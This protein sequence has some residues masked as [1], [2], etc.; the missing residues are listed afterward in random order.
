M[1]VV[2]E[3]DSYGL[4]D[5]LQIAAGFGMQRFGYVVTP[6]VDHFVRLHEDAGL[7]EAYAEADYVLLDS[8][9][10]AKLLELS[11]GMKVSVT[12]GSDLTAALFGS[13]IAPRDRIVVIGGSAQLAQGLARRHGLLEL[14]HHAPP[15][16]FLDDPAALEACLEFIEGHSPFRFCFL[17][18][19]S[20][21]QEI[22]ARTLRLRG[23][24]RG[25]ALCI[26]AAL[27]FL[28][29]ERERA[30]LWMQRSSLEWLHRL[31]QDPARLAHRYLVRGPRVFGLLRSTRISVR[32]A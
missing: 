28:G 18:V 27:E 4:A 8:R 19:G 23:R 21:R 32:S 5:S 1:T 11:R 14:H 20:P 26:G 12:T 6:N 29:G 3:L 22:V 7:R 25:L 13:V 15:M 16:G 10:L 9:V 2:L 31:L 17:A 24:A 30:P